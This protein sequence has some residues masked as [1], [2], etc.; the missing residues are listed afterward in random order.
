MLVINVKKFV[1]AILQEVARAHANLKGTNLEDQTLQRPVAIREYLEHENLLE[2]RERD[3][4]DKLYGLLSHTGAHPYMAEQDQAR[5]LRQLSLTI[6]Q[7][8][9]LRLDGFLKSDNLSNKLTPHL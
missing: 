2:K 8:I 5:L 3:T 1:E 7:F 4:L 9:L 6:T